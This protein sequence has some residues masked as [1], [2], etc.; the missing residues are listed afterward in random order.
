ME[1]TEGTLYLSHTPSDNSLSLISQ[2]NMPGSFCFSS[3]IYATTFG[4]VTRGLLPPIAP[5]K[6]EPVS[7][8]RAR[9]LET[10]PWDTLSCRDISQGLIPSCANSTM[11]RRTA[12]GR[13]RPFTNT[14]P[15]W[16]TSPYCWHWASVKQKLLSVE[17]KE[18]VSTSRLHYTRKCVN[19]YN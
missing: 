15:S 11:R 5:G 2:A 12:F 9:I 1:L 13:G 6:M 3:L 16:F 10:H 19:N 14:P 18:G 7:W 4:V 8:Y 17:T